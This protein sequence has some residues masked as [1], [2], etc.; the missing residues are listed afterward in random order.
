MEI[1]IPYNMRLNYLRI[2]LASLK[3][4]L[5]DTTD[6]NIK[7]Y[8]TN[9]NGEGNNLE[10]FKEFDNLE[11]KTNIKTNSSYQ[12]IQSQGSLISDIDS[13]MPKILN[14]VANNTQQDFLFLMD[15]DTLVHPMALKE[16]VKMCNRFQDLG[17][18]TVFNS[19]IS[20]FSEHI[21]DEYGK[22]ELIAGFGLIINKNIW[23]DYSKKLC[24]HWEQG[25]PK[26]I[27]D[28]TKL[29][30]YCTRNSY[31]EHIGFSGLHKT[32]EERG[33]PLS[34]DRALNFFD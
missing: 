10:I 23:K 15:A 14:E 32:N 11:I 7:L 16:A 19:M 8:N 6:F 26:Y 24:K 33:H 5:K 20:P 29:N 1:V 34:I 25:F 18:G 3:E 2:T 12:Q 9:K 21:D 4:A 30:I 31:L 22:K 27:H 13:F 17:A 28:K